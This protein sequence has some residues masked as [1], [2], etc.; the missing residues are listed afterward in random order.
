M[1]RDSEI[2]WSFWNE[3]KACDPANTPREGPFL[4]ESVFNDAMCLCLI[5]IP[6]YK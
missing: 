6:I 1:G 2:G 4:D 3:S 5:Q